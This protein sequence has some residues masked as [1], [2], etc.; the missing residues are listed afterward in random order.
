[1]D[2]ILEVVKPHAVLI[3]LPAQGHINSM[4]KLAKLL[5]FKGFHITFVNTEFTH[6]RLLKSRGLNALDGLPDFKY[7]SIPD[8]LPPTDVDAAQDIQSLGESVKKTCLLPLRNLLA[9]LNNSASSGV[10]PPVSCIVSDGVMTF[11]IKAAQELRIPFVVFR[12]ISACG[13]LCY[14]HC[15]SLLD[16]G[17][18]PLKDESYLRNGYLETEVKW[19]PGL[20]NIRLRDYPSSF[21]TTDPNDMDL[22]FLMGEGDRTSQASA[23]ILNTFDELES[24][25]L[26]CLASMFPPIYTIGPLNLLVNQ[27]PQNNLVSFGS[28]LW[29]EDT[30]CLQWLESKKPRTVVYVNYGSN[31]VMT[32]DQIIEFAWGLANSRKPFLWVIR[33]DLVDGG[34]EILSSEFFNETKD[35]GLIVSWCPQEQVLSHPSIG[36]FLTHCGWNST[37]ESLSWGVPMICWPFYFEQPTNCRFACTEWGIGLELASNV[38]RDEVQKMVNELIEGEKGK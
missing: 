20:K 31:T 24:D 25:A 3:P 35:R 15:R 30:E 2:A 11:S 1:M 33:P 10:V 38:K 21:R 28:N 17:T 26:N 22:D 6:K 4:L 29:K 14:A 16:K 5:H 13:F 18:I 12:T 23:I 32:P 19:I 36:G 7:E 8:G 37:I 9:K 34:S 27:I